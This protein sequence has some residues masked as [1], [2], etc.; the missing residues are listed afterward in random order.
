MQGKQR[1]CG[2]FQRECLNPRFQLEEWK[3]CLIQKNPKQ[4]FHLG[5]VTWKVRRRN[6]WRGSANLQ[7]NRHNNYTKS[8]LHVLTTINSKK[9]DLLDN[10][11]KYALKLSSVEL[12]NLM[13]YCPENKL[14]RAV[15][16]WTKDSNKHL[17]LLISYIHHTCEF[18]QYCYVGHTTQQCR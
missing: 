2:Q 13:F 17:A 11:Q 8:Q 1:Y 9:K 14:V 10:G 16:K 5:P 6:A 7:T 4:T 3:G 15:T 12:E 18:K